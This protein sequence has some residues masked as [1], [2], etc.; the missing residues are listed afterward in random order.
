MS[1]KDHKIVCSE[2]EFDFYVRN[3]MKNMMVNRLIDA[4][5]EEINR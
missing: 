4:V 3:K 5:G 1:S 2:S